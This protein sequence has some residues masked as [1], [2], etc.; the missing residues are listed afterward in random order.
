[1]D[2]T[3]RKKQWHPAFCSA[4]KLEFRKNKDALY[5]TSE[6]NINT[7]PIQVDL[8]VIKKPKVTVIDNE[9]GKLFRGHNLMEYK[10]PDDDL[11]EDV[12]WK[13]LGYAYLYKANEP[14]ADQIALEDITIT[15]VRKRKPVKLLK[16]LIDHY[17]FTA[18]KPYEGIY[19]IT[20]DGFFP[21]QIVVSKE[22]AKDEHIWLTSLTN[23]MS[24]TDARKLIQETDSLHE[25]DDKDYADSVFQLSIQLNKAIF[26]QIR[27]ELTMCQALREL[28]KPEIDEE[29]RIA[30]E[31]ATKE[32]TD[33]VTREVTDKVTQE[34][35]NKVT[36]EVTNKVT[37]EVT[38]K[39]TK[40]VTSKVTKENG[41][42]IFLNMIVHGY[43]K[44]E[45]QQMTEI[46]DAQVLE[47]MELIG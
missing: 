47:A 33:K 42:R 35:T 31:K 17:R 2:N 1:M 44:T 18:V 29:I 23:E 37:K 39:V 9:L 43:S 3:E 15:L 24:E 4:I 30:T 40:E 10:S 38:N 12:L 11:N 25:K 34:V 5:Y 28:L 7:K 27:E 22:L 6:Y 46:T 19:Y 36:K 41:I 13:V 45:A 32:V 14:K 20:K 8:L 21:I 26:N 16:D